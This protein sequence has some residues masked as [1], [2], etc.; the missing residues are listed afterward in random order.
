MKARSGSRV[1]SGVA[2]AAL[3]RTALAAS[4]GALL[5]F[6][7]GPADA[8]WDGTQKI[9]IGDSVAADL[10]GTETH[11]FAF[12]VPEGT[13][14]TAKLKA[15]KGTTLVPDLVLVDATLGKI[16]T[17]AK[18]TDV[19]NFRLPGRGAFA[20]QVNA[21]SGSGEYLLT[22]KAK[23]PKKLGT[24]G[25][26][27]LEFD[28]AA[29]A[30]TLVTA[31]VKASKGSAAVP[32]MTAF[33]GPAGDVAGFAESTS[34]KKLSL[35]VD[36]TYVVTLRNDGAAGSA[37]DWEV[38][39]AP[40]KGGRAWNM[41]VADNP[42][43][44]ESRIREQW[45]NSGH[46]DFTAEAFRHWDADIPAMV[47]T[48]C[49]R[50]HVGSGYEDY[51][52]S[53]GSTVNVVDSAHE[54]TRT[55]D[56]ETCHNSKTIGLT[57][58][59]FTASGK[60]V[61][62]LGDESR[63]M[64][65]HQGRESKKTVDDMIAA[66]APADVDTVSSKIRF[67]NVHYFAAAGSLYGREAQ[68]AYEYDGLDYEKKFTHVASYAA[69]HKCHDQHTLKVR[70]NECIDCHEI[71]PANATNPALY[72]LAIEQLRDVRMA[73]TVADYDGD[74]DAEEGVY[75]ELHGLSDV[76]YATIREYARDVTLKPILYDAH[77][78]P[79]W[80]EDKG[81]IGTF[82]PGI[83][84]GYASWTARLV[85]AAYNY[86][87]W[88]KDPGGFAHNAKYLMETLYDSIADLAAH[89]LVDVSTANGYPV[90]FAALVRNDFGHFDTGADAY[91]RWDTD[92][93]ALVDPSCARCHSVDGFLFRAKYGIDTTLPQQ[94]VAGMSCE[95]CHADGADFKNDPARRLFT[96]V[97]FP[98]PTT[99]T[100]TQKNAVTITGSSSAAPDDSYVC[101]QCHQGRASML[102]ID[103]YIATQTP[104]SKNMSFQNVHY[105]PAGAVQYGKQAAV[106]YQFTGKTYAGPWTHDVFTPY[107]PTW[108]GVPG[109]GQTATQMYDHGRCAYCHMDEGTH[110]FEPE[111]TA[112]CR[113]CH[114]GDISDVEDLRADRP[115]DYDG[116]GNFTEPVKDEVEA[117]AEIL[118]QQMRTYS[119]ANFT[120][121][122]DINALVYESHS[123]PYYFKDKNGNGVCD[124][125]T[126]ASNEATSANGF[127]FDATLLKA[128]HNYQIFQKD[129]GAWAHNTNYIVQLLIDSIEAVGGNV[130][131]LGRP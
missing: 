22:T 23:F 88:Q 20:F 81:V 101:M 109:T 54:P 102:T 131:G 122:S 83:D 70:V 56:C 75:H 3:L 10:T 66:A 11:Q 68:I 85:K 89:D 39:L 125:T 94:P 103:A 12:Y 63:C 117:I 19:K 32:V 47:P 91:R 60:T 92:A 21:D 115:L 25:A 78:Y 71:S 69:C 116:D 7:G 27:A 82:E 106:G 124:V 59:T 34:F 80:F 87:Y 108:I 38:Q 24:K 113:D 129:P 105:Y 77:S 100:T 107:P 90:D 18:P 51:L 33:E 49:G 6:P 121:G 58:V 41:G 37:F 98:Y 76:L 73:G 84:T 57:E 114:T 35:P 95:S 50:C 65:C 15:A 44:I 61:T 43:G 8:A 52:G 130:T 118:Y 9:R 13:Q 17:G 67:R 112:K 93:D 74:G 128:A 53:D 111:L 26:T 126:D 55:V 64:V 48:S 119:K 31:K 40:P 79:Y 104:G 110:S 62:G 42:R 123:H 2:Q 99:A 14:I 96:R 36:G 1:R 4:V 29:P 72:D 86:Q 46:A 5:A 45:L 120:G 16:D 97:E 28:F 30:G 127:K